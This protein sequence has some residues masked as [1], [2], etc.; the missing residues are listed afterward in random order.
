MRRVE[1]IYYR[2]DK[3][4][5][6]RVIVG[7]RSNGKPIFMSVYAKTLR[8]LKEKL[9]PLKL[10]YQILMSEQGDSSMS[11]EDW[12]IEWL[13]EVQIDVKESTFANYEYKLNFYALSV[14]GMYS[15]NELDEAVGEELLDSLFERDLSPSTI[16]GIFRIVKQCVNRAIDKKLIKVNPFSKIKLPKIM[17]KMNQALTKQEQK[18]LETAA[19]EEENGFGLPTL[20]ALHAGVR[21]GE[22]AALPWENV[23]FE[24]NVI[25]IDATYQRVFTPMADT[26][27]TLVYSSSKSSASNRVI[28]MSKTLRKAL[29]EH[30]KQ[31]V[32]EFVFSNK[33]N[34]SEPRLLTYHFHEIR[35]IAGLEHV[36][37]HQLRHTFATRCV[38]SNGDIVSVSALMGHSSAKM[39]L[40]TYSG[41]MM[42]QRIQVVNQ[43][44][45][46][47]S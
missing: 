15:L 6:G 8:E 19:I 13:R 21:I 32:G 7:R 29:L 5:E 24:N 31:A 28:P 26:R 16:Q 41:S 43:M 14:I 10:K 17:K 22:A 46:A 25:R 12:G 35:K 47:I 42:E 39:T 44:E 30:K 11:F 9:L 36:H 38:E 4:W 27:T 2:K 3:R 23:D 45:A 20:M 37:F 1:N 40:D 34:P 33:E 18:S